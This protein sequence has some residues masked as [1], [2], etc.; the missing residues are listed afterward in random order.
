M[1]I[2]ITA[3]REEISFLY[4]LLG[5][6]MIVSIFIYLLGLQRHFQRCIGHILMGRFLWGKT[7]IQ[8]IKVLY[9]KIV[10]IGTQLCHRGSGVMSCGPHRWEASVL[11]LYHCGP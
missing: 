5:D 9:C 8:F 1:R 2:K 3:N 4:L 10:I 7:S 11:P 6:Y